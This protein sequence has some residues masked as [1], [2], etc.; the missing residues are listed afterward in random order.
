M[1][2][3]TICTDLDKEESHIIAAY[4]VSHCS[5]KL[6]LYSSWL[7][8][9]IQYKKETE[10]DESLA[11]KELKIVDKTRS[12]IMKL[13]TLVQKHKSCLEQ[14]REGTKERSCTPS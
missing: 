2:Y 13:Q 5:D 1:N 6:M 10:D 11:K 8:I 12:R 3:R 4:T 14:R 7:D 9:V